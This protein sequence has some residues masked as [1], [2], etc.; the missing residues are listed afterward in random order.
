[1]SVPE[2][3][4]SL[5]EGMARGTM[6]ADL[7]NLGD[8][9]PPK[10]TLMRLISEETIS[11]TLSQIKNSVSKAED[12]GF[13]AGIIVPIDSDS[14]ATMKIGGNLKEPRFHPDKI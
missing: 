6:T 3:A 1:M 11:A 2:L 9:S 12:I 13:Y 7:T 8:A 10:E 4:K 5:A 14:N